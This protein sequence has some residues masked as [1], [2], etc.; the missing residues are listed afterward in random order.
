MT[1]SKMMGSR[2]LVTGAAGFIGAVLCAVLVAAGAHVTG[3]SRRARQDDATIT[4]RSADFARPAEVK[5]L[6]DEARPDFIFH[7]AAHVTGARDLA[8]VLPALQANCAAAVTLMTAA[9]ER[10][11]VR[12][13]L[14]NSLEEPT[15]FQSPPHSPYA[16]AKLASTAYARM[17]HAL[18][19]LHVVP[20]RIAMGYGPRQKDFTKLV[21]YAI[22][23]LL[24]GETPRYSSGVRRC[25]WI[26]GDDIADGLIAAALS[27]QAAGEVVD[28]GSGRVHSVGDV[29]QTLHA[30]M[31]APPPRLGDT[32]DRAMER[33]YAPDLER[34]FALTGWRAKV[35]VKEGLRRTVDW[36][37]TR[38]R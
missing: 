35:D 29:V 18:Y 17:F 16:A 10:G 3:T 33:K 6:I 30:L 24:N 9:A 26:Y 1:A 4:W 8:H 22:R 37:R 25:D 38:M 32:P 19:G 23:C 2:V 12:V 14:A 34:T 27:E 36:H 13:V 5:A 20:A 15:D 28:I 11:G 7:L 31:G 21:P